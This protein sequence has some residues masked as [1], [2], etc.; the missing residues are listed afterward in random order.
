MTGKD[1]RLALLEL[2]KRRGAK[3]TGSSSSTTEP[4]ATP[5]LSVA[6]AEGPE[7]G[8]KRKRLVKASASTAAATAA[9]TEEESSGSP[10]V[11]RQRKRSAVE[12]ASSLQPGEIEV[13]EVEEGSS[14]PPCAQTAT[15]PINLPS[16]V[17]QLPPTALQLPSP[18]AGQSPGPSAHPAGGASAQAGGAPPPLLPI[19]NT[20]AECALE[21]RVK[22]LEHDKE[23]LRSDFEAA[24]GSVELMR[25]MVEKARR[26]YLAQVQETIKTEILMG[27][28]VSS[29]DCTVVELKAET[30]SLRQQNTQLL[31]ELESAKETA[32]AGEKRLEEVVGKLSETASSLAA[33][34]TERDAAEAS[35]QKLEAENADLMNVGADALTDGFE[36]ALEQIRCVLPD[37]DLSQFSIY[38]E[39]ADGK[40]IPPPLNTFFFSVNLSSAPFSY[41]SE[42]CIRLDREYKLS[43]C[44][45]L[46][47]A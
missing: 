42:I 14:P 16:P 3:G 13:V 6:P 31:G 36:L 23:S 35:K 17:H 20:A 4:I 26:E 2:A 47:V 9:S 19:P 33:I 25:G 21:K 40:L 30:S 34:T 8:K 43:I 27:E 12:G 45:S 10:L 18:L 22:D 44:M 32:A 24:Q 11:H 29:L 41:Y 38:H 28:A 1:R 5:P 15:D 7:P 37:L 46:F 39:V